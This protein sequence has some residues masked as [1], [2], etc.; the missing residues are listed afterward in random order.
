M[1]QPI[2][3]EAVKTLA[4]A[5]GVREAARQL[6]LNE[7]RVL[8]WSQRGNW[9]K[10]PDPTPQ[11]PTVTKNDVLTVRKPSEVLSTALADDSKATRIG[12]SKGTRKAAE[13]FGRLKGASVIRISEDLRRIVSSASQIHNWEQQESGSGVMG[14]LRVYASGQTVIQVA[15]AQPAGDS[16]SE[17]TGDAPAL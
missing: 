9:L 7:E 16:Q 2:D 3:R 5:V 11:P 1:K 13:V 6:G 8:K 10:Q 12:L 15:T 17:E 4:I 14:G